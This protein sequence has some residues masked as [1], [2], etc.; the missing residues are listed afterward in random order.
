VRRRAVV[1]LTAVALSATAGAELATPP[2][3]NAGIVGLGCKLLGSIGEGWMGSACNAV[4]GVGGKVLS[5]GKKAAGVLGKLAGNPLLQRGVGIGAIVAWV[6]GGAKWTVDHMAAVISH[7]TAPKLTAG[8]FT[9]VYLRVE[10]VAVFFTLLFLCAAAAEAL[11]RSDASV[12]ARAAFVQLPV[13]ALLTAVATPLAMLL[14][15]GTDQVSAG[16]A[17]IAGSGTTHFLTG[18]SAWVTAGL[19]AADPFFAVIAGGVVVAAGGALWVEMLVREISVYVIAAMLPLAFAAMVWPARRVWAVRTVEVLIALILSKVAVVVVLAIG[20]AA[21][22]HAGAGGLSKLLA[23]LA[24]VILGAFS[25]WLLLRLIPMAELA[26]A[27]VAHIRGHAHITAGVRTP[28][29]ALAGKAAGHFNGGRASNGAAR[30]AAG[31]IAVHELLEQMQRRTQAA[32]TTAQQNGV[33]AATPSAPGSSNGSLNSERGSEPA[34]GDDG[35]VATTAMPAPAD[36]DT[37]VQ[38][39]DG[40]WEPLPHTDPTAPIPPPPWQQ[41]PPSEKRAEPESS[42][43]APEPQDG[44]LAPEDQPE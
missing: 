6:L 39:P 1:L 33:P 23:G 15:A 24:L 10:A 20:G 29:A 18:T 5:G 8:W 26:S 43:P 17:G 16:F 30:D 37:M 2:P 34:P 28:E 19:T 35:P 7:T 36:R 41:Q 3:A 27:A 38:R 22:G 12:L 25:P 31:V 14:L 21:L 40:S 42:L 44:R 9:G 32:H 13:A 11:L 4:L